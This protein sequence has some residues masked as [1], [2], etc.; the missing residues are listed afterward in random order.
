M[1]F[2]QL[3][4]QDPSDIRIMGIVVMTTYCDHNNISMVIVVMLIVTATIIRH[5]G[6]TS[7]CIHNAWKWWGRWDRVHLCEECSQGQCTGSHTSQLENLQADKHSKRKHPPS[8]VEDLSVADLPPASPLP[9]LMLGTLSVPSACRFALS[10]YGSVSPDCV[11][12]KL[13][14]SRNYIKLKLNT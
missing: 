8:F 7:M 14:P 3:L 5:R 2:Q 4:E 11:E 1:E 6:L 10:T 13:F 9:A 12:Y